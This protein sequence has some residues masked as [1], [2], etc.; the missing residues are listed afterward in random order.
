MADAVVKDESTPVPVAGTPEYDKAMAE[1]W[2]ASQGNKPE[3]APADAPADKVE[4]KPEGIPDKFYDAKTG[5]VDYEGLAKSYTE[6]EKKIGK[7][8][9]PEEKPEATVEKP[10]AA[11]LEDAVTLATVKAAEAKAKSEAEGATDADKAAAIEAENDL[12]LA[13]ADMLKAAGEADAADEA[14][15]LV[16]GKGLDFDAMSNEYATTGVLSKETRELLEAK[17]IPEAYV[18]AFIS[19]QEALSRDIAN[20][21][22]DIVGGSDKYKTMVEWAKAALTPE[23]IASYDN[24]VE[25]GNI[26][27][28]KL[29]VSGMKSKYEEVNGAEPKLLGGNNN[30]DKGTEGYQSRQEM[31]K[32]MSD[33]RYER[34]PAFR[35]KVEQKVLHAAF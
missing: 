3:A 11:K 9:E 23:E 31:T 8:K 14:K 1:K 22:F 33:P 34:D 5:K 30:S 18:D 29:A 7:P 25:S 28:M 19:G 15:K 13:K 32:D 10:D 35:K 6:L 27:D 12:T 26:E 20:Q 16:E 17:G 21:A 4:P 24:A 2:E